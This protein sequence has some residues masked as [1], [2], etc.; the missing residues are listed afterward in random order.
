MEAAVDGSGGSSNGI[1]AAAINANDGMVVAASS[2]AE[3]LT[4]TTTITTATISQRC[5]HCWC[6]CVITIPSHR[7]LRR[8]QLPS[9]KTI[10]TTDAINRHFCWWWPPLPPLTMN[11]NHWLLAVVTIDWVKA[12]MA[13]VDSGNSGR[14]WRQWWQ[15]Y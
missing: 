14:H 13:V 12:A 3:Q 5:H 1:F 8:Q 4:T 2:T 10:I 9:M 6:Y 11:N 7:R 15:C